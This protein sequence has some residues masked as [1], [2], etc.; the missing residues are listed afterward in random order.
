MGLHENLL[1]GI[2]AYGEF[3]A[4]VTQQ[5]PLFH[6]CCE[7]IVKSA[8]R[9]CVLHDVDLHFICQPHHCLVKANIYCRSVPVHQAQA[10][11]CSKAGS[12]A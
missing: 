5:Q 2:Y 3:L 4:A 12:L 1:R 6:R 7:I 8:L 11:R 10:I 9:I